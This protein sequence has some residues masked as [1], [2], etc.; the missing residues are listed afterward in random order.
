MKIELRIADA[1]L[2]TIQ[3]VMF[4]PKKQF[5][6]VLLPLP[7]EEWVGKQVCSVCS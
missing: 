5:K 3:N 6:M 7:P 4:K 1:D 2:G